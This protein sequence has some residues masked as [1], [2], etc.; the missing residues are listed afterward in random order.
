[1]LP[2]AVTVTAVIIN[3][4]S[5]QGTAHLPTWCYL[6][7]FHIDSTVAVAVLLPSTTYTAYNLTL[8]TA[9]HIQYTPCG[10]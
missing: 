10:Y 8:A 5:S 4:L 1:M 3:N 2:V 9:T 6:G 7:R